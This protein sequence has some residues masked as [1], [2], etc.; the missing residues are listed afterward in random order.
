[1]K[2]SLI[3]ILTRMILERLGKIYFV[4]K[5]MEDQGG[6]WLPGATRQRCRGSVDDIN[7]I[8][9]FS[10]MSDTRCKVVL[11]LSC[12]RQIRT[13]SAL[14][15]QVK[16]NCRGGRAVTHR[17]KCTWHETQGLE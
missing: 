16:K 4:G 15:T 7:N 10:T 17:V 9:A 3:F 14:L 13:L 5:E 12:V 8:D 2:G 1:M 6:L 11:C